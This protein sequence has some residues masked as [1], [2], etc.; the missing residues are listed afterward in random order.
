ML[1]WEET[2]RFPYTFDVFEYFH[3]QSKNKNMFATR[4]PIEEDGCVDNFAY[5][6]WT[7]C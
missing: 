6:K 2:A 5:T 1:F 3:E 4:F 7:S